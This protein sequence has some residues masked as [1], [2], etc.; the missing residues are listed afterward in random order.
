MTLQSVSATAIRRSYF[1]ESIKQ[2]LLGRAGNSFGLPMSTLTTFKPADLEAGPVIL[3]PAVTGGMIIPT[4]VFCYV[5]GALEADLTADFG[6]PAPLDE[7]G[8]PVPGE[9]DEPWLDASTTLF[10]GGEDQG[11]LVM[12]PNSSVH[13]RAQ[14]WPDCVRDRAF[15]LALPDAPAARKGKAKKAANGDA[16]VV[17]DEEEAEQRYRAT[18]REGEVLPIEPNLSVVVF[19]IGL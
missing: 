17:K 1:D 16:D 5:D 9:H 8:E 14:I 7:E 11:S 4:N 12:L 19:Y 18:A 10:F 15:A 6:W 3:V 2:A 13:P